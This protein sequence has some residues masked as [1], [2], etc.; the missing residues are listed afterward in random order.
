M[1]PIK[2]NHGSRQN[3][4]EHDNKQHDLWLISDHGK[5]EDDGYQDIEGFSVPYVDFFKTQV[6][7][8]AHHQEREDVNHNNNDNR[9][10]LGDSSQGTGK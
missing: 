3:V 7:N 9:L 2:S 8:R 10:A 4:G 6:I 1:Q 5:Y